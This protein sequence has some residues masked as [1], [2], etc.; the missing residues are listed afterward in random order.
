M[1]NGITPS[2]ALHVAVAAT[3]SQSAFAALVGVKQPA[4]SK[5]LRE[6]KPL[7][8]EH[9][10]AVEA[11]TGV[12]KHDLRPDIYPREATPGADHAGY[13]ADMVVAR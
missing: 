7:P 3:G 1:P 13:P 2:E 10:L 11:A 12:S 5:W 6:N 4:V 9:V 8:P